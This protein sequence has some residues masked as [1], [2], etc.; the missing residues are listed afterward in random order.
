MLPSSW[1]KALGPRSHDEPVATV[2]LTE[3]D[4]AGFAVAQI[5]KTL[6]PTKRIR[7]G[8][9]LFARPMLSP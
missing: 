9:L 1:R 4:K 2:E 7:E 8:D 6:D 3:L 5:V